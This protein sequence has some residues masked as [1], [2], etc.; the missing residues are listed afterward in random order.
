M[1]STKWGPFDTALSPQPTSTKTVNAHDQAQASPFSIPPTQSSGFSFFSP[2]PRTSQVNEP[3]RFSAGST[4]RGSGL[5]GAIELHEDDE[6]QL[7]LS[8]F[9]RHST[10]SNNTSA[11][12]HS[13]PS[14]YSQ[15]IHE[16][17]VNSQTIFH[18]QTNEVDEAKRKA[19]A[20]QLHRINQ[21]LHHR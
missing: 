21:R 10:S 19:R 11:Y 20:A 13:Q 14:F 1:S 3:R 15:Q 8:T 4:G 7:P 2:Q 12:R 5:Y 18:A 16:S 17:P 6:D 9:R